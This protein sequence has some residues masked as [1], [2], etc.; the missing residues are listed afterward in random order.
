MQMYVYT[1]SPVYFIFSGFHDV[2]QHGRPRTSVCLMCP[3]KLIY[4]LWPQN[5]LFRLTTPRHCILI[6]KHL[7]REF[8]IEQIVQITGAKCACICSCLPCFQQ[9]SKPHLQFKLPL[10]RCRSLGGSF[11]LLNTHVQCS[12]LFF[13]ILFF[14]RILW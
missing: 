14:K 3:S 11:A 13:C 9:T 10:L 8:S 12:Y 2:I 5:I 4:S 1:R 6:Y 7:T